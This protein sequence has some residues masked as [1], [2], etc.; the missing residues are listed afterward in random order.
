VPSPSAAQFAHVRLSACRRMTR[1]VEPCQSTFLP[2]GIL[3]G[4]RPCGKVS[5]PLAAVLRDRLALHCLLVES[6]DDPI[7]LV[8]RRRDFELPDSGGNFARSCPPESSCG[9]SRFCLLTFLCLTDGSPAFAERSD[10]ASHLGL[11]RRVFEVGR[12]SCP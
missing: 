2:N 4:L 9:S 12:Q 11:A 1:R 3:P 8:P 10:Q 7:T 5:S 6:Y